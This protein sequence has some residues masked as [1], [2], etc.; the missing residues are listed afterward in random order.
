MLKFY[1]F[2]SYNNNA[3]VSQTKW[4]LIN[5]AFARWLHDKQSNI[6]FCILELTLKSY[7]RNKSSNKAQ[8]W[9]NR[10]LL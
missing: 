7:F 3:G 1:V 10:N 8:Q 5:K 9:Y 6:F 4:E 2:L